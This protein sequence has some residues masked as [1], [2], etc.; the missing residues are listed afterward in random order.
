MAG[1][2]MMRINR[3]SKG[4]LT[5]SKVAGQLGR[6]PIR[7]T[8]S[9]KRTEL[10]QLG[11]QHN[12]AHFCSMSFV[13]NSFFVAST[14]HRATS[15]ATIFEQHLLQHWGQSIKPDSKECLP[16]F[17]SDDTELVDESWKF[18]STMRVLGQLI[19]NRGSIAKGFFL[20]LLRKCGVPFGP[21][22]RVLVH[23]SFHFATN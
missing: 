21:I 17:G 12:D 7:A 10:L 13:D 22:V 4:G 8:L 2:T 19:N 16:C 20:R 11:W 23:E 6:I 18:M 1:D 15:M 14:V 5:G 9:D 3:R